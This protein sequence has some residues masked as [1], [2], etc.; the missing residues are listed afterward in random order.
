MTDNNDNSKFTLI[1][2]AIIGAVLIYL[3][4]KRREPPII[5][6][7]SNPPALATLTPT[8]ITPVININNS[9]LEERLEELSFQLQE[10]KMNNFNKNLSLIKPIKQEQLIKA[11]VFNMDRGINDS[12]GR[13]SISKGILNKEKYQDYYDVSGTIT[14]TTSVDPND[15]DSNIYDRHNIYTVMGRKSQVLYVAND[16]TTQVTGTLYVVVSHD[17]GL[18]SSKEE[19]IYANEIKE[20]HNVYNIKLRSPTQSLAY[21]VTEYKIMKQ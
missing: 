5:A 13:E 6:S 15:F 17:G 20:Y 11:E 9:V 8:T 21:R 7:A 16:A 2:G 18:N 12:K 4:M 3:I 10:I 1:I 19:P 14:N